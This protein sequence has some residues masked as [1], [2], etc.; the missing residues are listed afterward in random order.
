MASRVLIR[1]PEE[2]LNMKRLVAV[3]VFGAS[4]AA[5]VA[6]FADE[7]HRYYDREHHDWHEWNDREARAYRHWLVEERH[8]RY[9]EYAR[10][11]ARQRREYWEWRHA[12]EDWR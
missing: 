2:S 7:Y 1:C 9:R 10:L 8:E 4:L 3:L 6:S 11:R 12:H 5:P